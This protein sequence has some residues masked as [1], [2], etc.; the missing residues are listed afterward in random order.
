M[1]IHNIN[2]TLE[3]YNTLL[4]D[5]CE[6]ICHIN[7]DSNGPDYLE[8]LS[9]QVRMQKIIFGTQILLN[10]RE[11]K[12]MGACTV[13]Q[14][15]N[16]IIK[17][18]EKTA[19]DGLGFGI[20]LDNILDPIGVLDN[21]NSYLKKLDGITSRRVAAIATMSTKNGHVSEFISHKRA[22]EFNE[23][24]MN[25]SVT[26]TDCFMEAVIHPEKQAEDTTCA[27]IF[28]EI[29]ESMWY[30]GEPG[31]LFTDR[32][33][34][35]N[36]LPQYEYTGL[37]PCAELAMSPGE[38]CHF[39]YI[40]VSRFLY[41]GEFD[42]N[43]LINT[44]RIITI[45]LDNLLDISLSAEY[46]S[47]VYNKRRISIG[48]CGLAELFVKLMIP[49]GSKLSLELTNNIMSVI[50]YYSK[51]T[52]ADLALTRG[53]FPLLPKSMLLDHDWFFLHGKGT[54][55]LVTLTMWEHLWGRIT[56]TGIRNCATVALPPTGNSAYIN[57]TTY[58]IEP[59]FNLN[60]DFITLALRKLCSQYN[61]PY[62]GKNED[63]VKK[64]PL[65]DQ[66]IF[67]TSNLISTDCHLAILGVLQTNIDEAISKTINVPNDCTPSEIKKIILK[68]YTAKLK[69][70]TVFRNMCLEER[71][72]YKNG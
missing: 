5:L 60:Y 45:A 23:W 37:A 28:D 65:Y 56:K 58:S 63:A 71:M 40:N 69:G 1:K 50:N 32:I 57:G 59:L 30:C 33:N 15:D 44:T 42:Y 13:L 22:V 35:G 38:R 49:Y 16:N 7:P 70:I 62:E 55:Q 17:N 52:S 18:I 54:S 3:E 31:I 14:L 43:E 2:I 9:E 68:A 46:N 11:S 48:I 19:A 66:S 41:N 29:T 64:L 61:I 67:L 27:Q 24:R 12:T 47:I 20:N 53:S 39:A 26:A 72:E 51:M 25:L 21:I 4:N 34:E 6:A 8:S 10:F 36:P